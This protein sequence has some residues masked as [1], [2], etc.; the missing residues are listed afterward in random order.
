MEPLLGTRAEGRRREGRVK[1]QPTRSL[2]GTARSAAGVPSMRRG[3]LDSVVVGQRARRPAGR[4]WPPG[5]G[6]GGGQRPAP[7][8]RLQ[9]LAL[10]G[11]GAQQRG[12]ET[13]CRVDVA[14]P[15]GRHLDEP[16]AGLGRA[17]PPARPCRA[18]WQ[19][20][21]SRPSRSALASVPSRTLTVLPSTTFTTAPEGAAPCAGPETPARPLRRGRGSSA[22]AQACEEEG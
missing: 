17:A 20:G 1:T 10:G 19:A 13:F 5:L 6:L 7:L 12:V 4:A 3:Q 11:A 2:S 22:V 18:A 9:V 14:A 16:D 21:T 15:C 8:E